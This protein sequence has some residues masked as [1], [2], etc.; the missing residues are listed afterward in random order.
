MA[1]GETI[2]ASTS[3]FSFDHLAPLSSKRR[4]SFWL[5][6]FPTPGDSS[7]AFSELF[8]REL[9]G[10]LLRFFLNVRPPSSSPWSLIPGYLPSGNSL[11]NNLH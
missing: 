3:F 7:G 8:K 1:Y 4:S 6:A 9:N 2:A 10:H 11:F 5:E